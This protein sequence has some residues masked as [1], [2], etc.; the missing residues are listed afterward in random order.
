M[1]YAI[2]ASIINAVDL[3]ITKQV[4]NVFKNLRY[5]TFVIWLFVWIIIVGSLTAP[6]L[7]Q[8]DSAASS[9]YYLVLLL[10]LAVIAANHNLLYYFGLR[11][12]K[13]SEIEPFLLFEP[14]VT[15]LIASAFYANER[16]WQI[17]IAGFIAGAFLAWSHVKKHHL[18]L[19]KPLL[20]ILGYAV[21]VGFEAVIVK[22]LL[23]VYSPIALYVVRAIIV[24]LVLWILEKGQIGKITL[25]QIPYFVLLATTAIASQSLV[26]YAYRIQGIN[27]TSVVLMLSPVLIYF[28]S[29]LVLKEKLNWKNLIT[30][31]VVISLIV[32]VMLIK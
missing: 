7:I 20:A 3:I 12:E 9:L 1:I 8:I 32:W 21:L 29:V 4:F 22:Q 10:I 25:K 15:I 13:V 24:A 2:L 26:Y 16:I 14:L 6:W 19:G 17:Y 5:T 18:K 31:V 27:L 28:L 30:S 11:Y 23:A